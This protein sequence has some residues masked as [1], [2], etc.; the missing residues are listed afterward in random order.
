MQNALVCEHMSPPCTHLPLSFFFIFFLTLPKSPTTVTFVVV[1]TLTLTTHPVSLCSL[2]ASSVYFCL[3][4]KVKDMT[5]NIYVDVSLPF[6]I[7]LPLGWSAVVVNR[8]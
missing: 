5:G 8:W 2:V 6:V 1:K 4:A 3:L 7:D